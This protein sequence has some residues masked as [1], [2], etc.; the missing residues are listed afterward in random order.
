M[1]KFHL[2]TEMQEKLSTTEA[3]VWVSPDITFK[4]SSQLNEQKLVGELVISEQQ[5]D[6]EMMKMLL[7]V[8]NISLRSRLQQSGL[9]VSIKGGVTEVYSLTGKPIVDVPDNFSLLRV[10]REN[11]TKQVM[12]QELKDLV[13]GMVESGPASGIYFMEKNNTFSLGFGSESVGMITAN[14][15]DLRS[16]LKANSRGDLHKLLKLKWGDI[17]IL[18]PGFFVTNSLPVHVPQDITLVVQQ[19]ENRVTQTLTHLPS[20]IIDPGFEGPIMMERLRDFT[21]EGA[22]E[23]SNLISFK[24][25]RN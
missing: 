1:R 19:A 24:A 4:V 25:Y 20:V 18:R 10:F 3:G 21:E 5:P 23:K 22:G 7:S 8:G 12:G 15:I 2:M 16:I 6:A 13:L 14:S 9:N 17:D 11:P